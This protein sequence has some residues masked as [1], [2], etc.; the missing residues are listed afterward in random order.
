MNSLGE[1]ICIKIGM[2]EWFV[3]QISEH[4]PVYSP[5]RLENRKIWFKRPGRA[6]TFTPIVGTVHEW[7]TSQEVTIARIEEFTGSWR[8]SL[9]FKSRKVFEF[10]I[11][12]SV[13][14]IVKE[15]YS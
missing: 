3:P 13:S 5:R 10:S 4:C 6:S 14:D 7:I 1:E 15:V 8:I 11:K 12:L 9:V 2:K